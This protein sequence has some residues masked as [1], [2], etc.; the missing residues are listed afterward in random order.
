MTD[1]LQQQ[2]Q[3]AHKESDHAARKALTGVKRPERA[4]REETTTSGADLRHLPI[5]TAGSTL[6]LVLLCAASQM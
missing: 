3:P 1:M 6:G 5:G 4:E 2:Q